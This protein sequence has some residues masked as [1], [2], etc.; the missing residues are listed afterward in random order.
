MPTFYRILQHEQPVVVDFVSQFVLGQMLNE[1]TSEDIR[2]AAGIS[3]YNTQ[4]QAM[5]KADVLQM[6]SAYV[7]QIDIPEAAEIKY[8][9]TTRSTGHHTLWGDPGDILACWVPPAVRVRR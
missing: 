3:A 6:T 4:A 2:L 7:V 5:N 8:E 1:P 9:R